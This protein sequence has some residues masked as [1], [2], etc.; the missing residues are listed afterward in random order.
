M[1]RLIGLVRLIRHRRLAAVAVTPLLAH[2]HVLHDAIGADEQK[3][4]ASTHPLV[5]A[6]GRLHAVART[7]S[8]EAPS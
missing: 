7:Y 5:A 1:H 3:L 8:K 2:D 6:A 4:L